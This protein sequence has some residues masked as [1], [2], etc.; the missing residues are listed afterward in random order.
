MVHKQLGLDLMTKI[1]K[2]LEEYS[3]IDFT[4]RFEGKSITTIISPLKK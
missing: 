1:C 2:D 4:P 3:K